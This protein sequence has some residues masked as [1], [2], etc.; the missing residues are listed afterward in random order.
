MDQVNER[1]KNIEN[2]LNQI[3]DKSTTQSTHLQNGLSQLQTELE[4]F[5]IRL[6]EL[7]DLKIESKKELEKSQRDEIVK[8]LER[9]LPKYTLARLDGDK[10]VISPI[11]YRYLVDNFGTS[12]SNQMSNKELENVI[13]TL[14]QVDQ[15]IITKNEIL[16]LMKK[17]ITSYIGT[18]EEKN[19]EM[20][21]N[22]VMTEIEALKSKETNSDSLNEVMMQ[23]VDSALE[24]YSADKLGLADYALASRGTKIVEKLTSP[25]FQEPKSFLASLFQIGTFGKP[26]ITALTADTSLGNCWSFSG[27]QGKLTI[28]LGHEVALNMFTLDHVPKS[29]ALDASSAPKEVQLWILKGPTEKDA[30]YI[31]TW[32]FLENPIQTFKFENQLARFV[33][34]RIMSNQGHP[35]YTCLYRF[36]LHSN[37]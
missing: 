21:L 15:K 2:A 9:E 28:D 24:K 31:G 13:H 29:L 30:K 16:S 12:Q 3:Q 17:E 35:K 20:T 33:Q 25:S 7:V 22:K 14:E 18:W 37:L 8:F 23:I 36:R 11:F 10:V 1:F 34:L 6:K 5:H 27:S 4:S 32:H 19:Y 26:A